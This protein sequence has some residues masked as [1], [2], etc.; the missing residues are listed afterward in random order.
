MEPM[1][2]CN[3][4]YDLRYRYTQICRMVVHF[5]VVMCREVNVAQ[6]VSLPLILIEEWLFYA[7]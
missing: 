3:L 6:L 4:T 1:N 2:N 5:K 7:I